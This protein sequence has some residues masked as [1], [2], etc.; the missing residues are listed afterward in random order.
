MTSDGYLLY[1]GDAC[2]ALDFAT[3]LFLPTSVYSYESLHK[4]VKEPCEGSWRD[5]VGF[6]VAH[7]GGLFGQLLRALITTLMIRTLQ[8]MRVEILKLSLMM[9]R[10]IVPTQIDLVLKTVKTTTMTAVEMTAQFLDDYE[11]AQWVTDA[12][13][14]MMMFN[15]LLQLSL[16]W[17]YWEKENWYS[18]VLVYYN[19]DSR[20]IDCNEKKKTSMVLFSFVTVT[21]LAPV[22]AECQYRTLLPFG[23]IILPPWL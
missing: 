2:M 6:A 12:C 11:W 20:Y 19:G 9:L 4:S 8:M 22:R 17:L 14:M 16:Q 7:C 3:D 21:I 23:S 5:S 10:L 13:V 18:Y 15:V 1:S